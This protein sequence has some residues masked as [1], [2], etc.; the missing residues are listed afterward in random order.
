MKHYTCRVCGGTFPC[1]LKNSRVLCPSCCV[2]SGQRI[3]ARE[4]AENVHMRD[5]KKK[6]DEIVANELL[7][8]WERKKP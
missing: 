8:P 6:M 3:L 2:K 7:M 4:R 5:L 1:G